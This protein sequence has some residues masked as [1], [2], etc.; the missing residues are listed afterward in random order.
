MEPAIA[1]PTRSQVVS[2]PPGR[3]RRLAWHVSRLAL[4]SFLVMVAVADGIGGRIGGADAA[5]DLATRP[6]PAADV[7]AHGPLTLDAVALGPAVP[8]ASSARVAAAAPG[9]LDSAEAAYRLGDYEKAARLL[10]DLARSTDRA[11]ANLALL[12]LAVVQI[13]A[14]RFSAAADAARE[15]LGRDLDGPTRARASFVLGRAQRAAGNVQDAIASF[16][17][18]QQAAPDLGPYADLAAAYGFAT[19]NDRA[20]QNARAG[21]AFAAAQARLTKVDA[22]E[23]QVTALLKLG[24]RD[25]A[26]RA[27]NDLLGQSGTRNY[28]AQ[29]LASLGT[30]AR[31]ADKRD[32][33]L[34][35]FATVVAELPESPSAVGAL[36]ALQGMNGMNMVSPDEP[37][38]VLFFA[39]RYSEAI[40]ALRA[41]I[42]GGLSTERTARARFYLG[43]A[44]LRS[45]AA[46]DGVAAMR[47]VAVDMPGSDW[48][49]RALLRAGRRLE[50][51]GRYL[52]A[53]DL[54]RESAGV[55]PSSAASQEA[56]ARL[57]F[58]QVMRGTLP[59]AIQSTQALA[60]GPADG[61]WKGLGLLW[62]AKGLN[63]AGDRA[64][65]SALLARAADADGVGFG[66][67]RARAILD[68]D[69]GAVNQPNPFDPAA[70]QPT[71]DDVAGLEG[72][73]S[74]AGLDSSTLDREQASDPAYQRAALLYQVG[75]PE[76]ASWELQELA[77]RWEND[78]PRL[79][80]LA[81]FAAEHGDATLGMRL[82][83][84]AQ[85]ATNAT[86]T[87]QPRLLQ[88]L[89]YP[90]PY[91]EAIASD[92]KARNVDPLLFAGLI[93][94]ES[95]FNPTARSS[96]NALG[97]AQVVPSTGQGIAAALGRP[98]DDADLYR[99]LVAIDFG[100]FYLGRQL[101][102][103]QGRIYPA[104]AAYNAGG[105]TV[106]GWLR[107]L[108]PG[109]PDLFIELIPYAETSQ[110]LHI[111]YENYQHYRRLYR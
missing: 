33:A 81:R 109:D 49:A 45:G 34:K 73:L 42:Q 2:R 23:H 63:K 64:Q 25:G 88:R 110:Y 97:L 107:D 12:R 86:L 44:L 39:G 11:A 68:G 57:V 66:G 100:T 93:R 96:A 20:N 10:R 54:F 62:A 74:G 56:Q 95:A 82:A 105:G 102:S 60:D 104:L 94:Q 13:D 31:D 15:L 55:L 71:P 70:A 59:E 106:N 38:A 85:K 8:S 48:A 22:L 37:P 16:D 108:D 75:L 27:S 4:A 51:D 101:S 111:V 5:D 6:G 35:A 77:S 1:V 47:Q 53:S 36:E 89:I 91:V 9:P 52:D 99:P 58:V 79:F 7:W 61:I 69:V 14:G 41:A 67:L 30:I 80:G 17:Q 26:L 103:Y 76:W 18:A 92:A 3:R 90:L 28:R 87:A 72:W 98:I 46:D 83:S 32:Q 50:S 29:T 43:Q 40:P 24:D 78:P 84:A 65:A 21:K 19:L